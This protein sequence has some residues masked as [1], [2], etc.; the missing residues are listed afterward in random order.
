MKNLLWIFYKP[1]DE[2][3][4]L[5]YKNAFERA[6][7]TLTILIAFG[8][9]FMT[10][11][12]DALSGEAVWNIVFLAM[13]FA[14]GMGWY[15]LRQEELALHV[16]PLP[17][18]RAGRYFAIFAAIAA[19]LPVSM[20][21]IFIDV[22]PLEYLGRIMIG[23][24]V[25]AE[26]VAIYWTWTVAAGLSRYSRVLVSLLLA[27]GFILFLKWKR[28]NLLTFIWSQVVAIGTLLAVFLVLLTPFSFFIAWP[29]PVD[30]NEFAPVL[31]EG[32]WV[33]VDL[34]LQD[35]QTGDYVLYNSGDEPAIGIVEQTNETSVRIN[36]ADVTWQN[37]V[38]E[39]VIRK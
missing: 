37:I 4:E 31:E 3:E 6:F 21:L 25:L 29:Y 5:I 20:L 12:P 33:F 9:Y 10:L 30:T 14:Y 34:R 26:I 8:S 17:E 7:I 39:L 35:V 16:A 18:I 22:V 19:I 36:S 2:R 32:D 11:F 15:G 1:V 27:P 24:L 23:M 38:G 13:L 28:K